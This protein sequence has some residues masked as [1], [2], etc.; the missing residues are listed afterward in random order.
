VSS[1]LDGPGGVTIIEEYERFVPGMFRPMSRSRRWPRVRALGIVLVILGVGHVPLPA[2]DYHSIRH[3][4]GPGEVCEHHDHLMRWHPHAGFAE[5]VAILHWHLFM[6]ASGSSDQVPGPA[7]PAM[8]AHTADLY[9]PTWDDGPQWEP[10]APLR[11]LDPPTS[12]FAGIL[13]ASLTGPTCLASRTRSGPI[14]AFSA[15]FAPRAPLTAL[16]VRW[17]C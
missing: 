13:L 12:G 14:H 10:G 8:H 5:D 11:L 9:T 1:A 15:T 3:H 4:D 6:P 17:V 2:P 16:Y 7:G